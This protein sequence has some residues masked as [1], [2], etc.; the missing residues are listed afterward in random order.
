MKTLKLLLGTSVTVAL[1][2]QIQAQDNFP[3]NGLT[4]YYKFDENAGMTA[5]SATNSN[6]GTL[7][8]GASW[9]TTGKIYSGINL[10]GTKGCL[11]LSTLPTQGSSDISIGA[12]INSSSTGKREEIIAYGTPNVLENPNGSVRLYQTISGYLECD[13]GDISL[14]G[15]YYQG[16]TSSI[17]I[18][19]GNWHYVCV[20]NSPQYDPDADDG[21]G[22]YGAYDETM[23]LFIDGQANGSPV[24]N[25]DADIQS[26][27]QLIGAD[28]ESGN[29]YNPPFYNANFF[30]GT[31]DEVGIW[32]RGLTAD[33]IATLYNNGAGLQPYPTLPSPVINTTRGGNVEGV[34][35]FGM[36]VITETTNCVSIQENSLNNGS[37]WNTIFSY[38]PQTAPQTNVFS[39]PTDNPN[40]NY[41]AKLIP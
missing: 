17:K 2:A 29:G 30:K 40:D 39:F 31:I 5:A 35:Q 7:T 14:E 11:N 26:G 37:S 27:Y 41:R 18:N 13:F 25:M 3:Y 20:V 15:D 36:S 24:H 38:Y 9:R 4:A 10:D 6:T 33:E 21:N 16:P 22:G 34:P 23:Q 12:W 1:A 8:N 28:Y 19:D 32:N